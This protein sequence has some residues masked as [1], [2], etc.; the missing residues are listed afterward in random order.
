MEL[1][2]QVGTDS[3]IN[4]STGKVIGAAIEVHTALG[5][6]LLESAYE[7]CLCHEFNLQGIPYERQK[8]LPVEY[9]GV[10]LDC[11]YRLDIIVAE[12]LIVELKSVEKL[13]PIHEAQLLTYLKMTGIKIGL[14]INFNV[15]LL[16][17][18][19]KRLAN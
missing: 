12:K 1:R 9:K 10:K 7:E 2:K 19:I 8:E 14:L 17:D 11:G 5:P 6:G 13:Q 15:P 16:K 3:D 18:G 4:N